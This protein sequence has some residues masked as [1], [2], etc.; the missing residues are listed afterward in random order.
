MAGSVT[1]AGILKKGMKDSGLTQLELY[2]LYRSKGG[3]KKQPG[4][5]GAWLR[6]ERD[7]PATQTGDPGV[8]P[9]RARR[10]EWRET[11]ADLIPEQ[12]ADRPNSSTGWGGKQADAP[13][14]REE[15]C[16]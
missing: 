13:H 16:R 12:S 9:Q 8:N 1:V 2:E 5:I 3:T 6:E 4:T 15:T 10:A 7:I 11:P 14:Q